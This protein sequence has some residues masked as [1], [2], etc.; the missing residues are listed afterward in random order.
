MG[1]FDDLTN[2]GREFSQKAKEMSDI[3]SMNSSISKMDK[4]L[5]ELYTCLGKEYYEAH[6]YD[7]GDNEYREYIEQIKRLQDEM[8]RANRYVN[9]LKGRNNIAGKDT[10]TC[11]DCGRILEADAGF[12]TQCGRNVKD[13]FLNSTQQATIRRTPQPNASA[14]VKKVDQHVDI[15]DEKLEK[16]ERDLS[17]EN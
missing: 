10:K 3:A 15:L 16:L 6:M 13:V 14:M 5:N 1:V 11:P 12:C 7:V 17:R 2:R 8:E 9:D 4:H